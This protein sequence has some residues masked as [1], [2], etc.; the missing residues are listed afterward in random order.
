[1]KS[2]FQNSKLKSQGSVAA[3][4]RVLLSAFCVFP[5]LSCLLLMAPSAGAEVPP[6]RVFNAEGEE[7]GSLKVWEI[8][9][10]KYV[11]LREVSA[12]FSGIRKSK[13]LIRQETVIIRGKEIILTLGRH[14]LKVDGEE[15]VLT[16]PPTSMSDETVVPVEFLT[17]ILPNITGR[18]IILDREEWALQL[19]N[20]PFVREDGN[21]VNSNVLPDLESGKFRVIID[22]G[23]GGYDS[24]A[25]SK[26]GLL[27][28]ELTLRIAQ[29]MKE[30]L[31]QQK[32][33]EV[34][35]TRSRDD[36]LTL[37]ERVNRANTLRGHAYLSVHFNW[38]PSSRSRGFRTYVNSNRTRLRGADVSSGTSPAVGKLSG[39]AGF[40]PQS[41][42]LA[43][44]ITDGLESVRLTGK[45][46]K[47]VSLAFM[48]NLSMPGVLVEVL[49]LSNPQDLRMLSMPD[50][51]DSVSQSLCDS[52]LNFRSFRE[53][54]SGFGAA[55]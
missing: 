11:L 44:E 3:I 54:K 9:G 2:F 42:Q 29:K 37:E 23:H 25:R 55:R 26:D 19:S 51:I 39:S 36:Y 10:A 7:I 41:K 38:S 40:L 4:L 14:R 21:E 17:E 49:Y 27:E 52:I 28:K 33:I 50:F 30:L 34:Y 53:G 15:Y 46:V 24:G 20:E 18:K 12:L 43:Q 45:Q 35:L 48:D 32:G 22:P 13:L 16:N 8:E 5:I 1:M 31:A 6:L 47:E